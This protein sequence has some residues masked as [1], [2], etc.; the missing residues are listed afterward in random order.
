MQLSRRCDFQDDCKLGIPE[1]AMVA[2]IVKAMKKK[3]DPKYKCDGEN[4]NVLWGNI[5]FGLR[6]ISSKK[7]KKIIYN[8]NVYFFQINSF[9]LNNLHLK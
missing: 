4:W 7:K 8:N 9:Y 5:V 1:V 6:K 3:V 2:T